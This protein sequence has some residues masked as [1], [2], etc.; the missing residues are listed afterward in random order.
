MY[1]FN[2]SGGVPGRSS[3]WGPDMWEPGTGSPA[4]KKLLSAR[5]VGGVCGMAL[6]LGSLTVAYR[7]ASAAPLLGGGSPSKVT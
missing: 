4:M 6:V 3:T 1:A 5:V 7:A 2:G